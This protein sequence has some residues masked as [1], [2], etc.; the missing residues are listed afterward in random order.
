[1]GPKK[2]GVLRIGVVMPITE[3]QNSGF[4]LNEAIRGLL[5]GYLNGPAAEAVPLDGRVPVQLEME[6][7]QKECDYIFYSAVRRRQHSSS[8]A[9]LLKTATPVIGMIPGGA[10]TTAAG[11]AG[12]AGAS[13]TD[14]VLKT[15]TDV[16]GIVKAK[17]E[18]SVEYKLA[19]QGALSAKVANVLKATAKKDGDQ[20]LS[21]LLAQAANA[22][23]QAVTQK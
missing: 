6:S 12:A 23:L 15:A 17:D 8:F 11:A 5:I 14:M 10:A 19:A 1:L 21:T 7:K 18:V 22:A 2:P 4:G 20:V 9:T 16:S 3:V 13:T